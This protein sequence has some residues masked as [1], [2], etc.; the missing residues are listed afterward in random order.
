ML[1][2]CYQTK[3]MLCTLFLLAIPDGIWSPNIIH[4]FSTNW[5][6]YE[7]VYQSFTLIRTIHF[8]LGLVQ[9]TKGTGSATWQEVGGLWRK[10]WARTR[11]AL[12]VCVCMCTCACACSPSGFSTQR[13]PFHKR[14][15]PSVLLYDFSWFKILLVL[16]VFTTF[17]YLVSSSI[18]MDFKCF[19]LHCSLYIPRSDL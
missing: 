12:C 10:H 13:R 8:N 4:M 3:L 15:E 14:K 5:L 11:L 9:W 18:Q 16:F 17:T 7:I 6:N 1:A 2:A 19:V